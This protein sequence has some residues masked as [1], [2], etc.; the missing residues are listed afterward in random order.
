MRIAAKEARNHRLV[1][2]ITKS[3]KRL[4][5]RAAAIEGQSVG[6][7]VIAHACR[8]AEKLVQTHEVIELNAEQ[9]RRLVEALIRPARP[10]PPA[11]KKATALYKKMVVN[12]L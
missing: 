5:E 8:A 9:S 4:L 12:A 11:L 10:V 1:A 6:G 3:R 7:F 2:R